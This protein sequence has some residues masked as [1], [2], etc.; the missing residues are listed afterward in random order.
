M[1]ATTAQFGQDGALLNEYKAAAWLNLSVATLRGWRC[2]GR[3]PA[4]IH[5]G[6][7]VRYRAKDLEDYIR[8]NRCD[9]MARD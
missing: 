6:R 4:V 1:D 7:A 2:S 3:G 8:E 5:L 9:P